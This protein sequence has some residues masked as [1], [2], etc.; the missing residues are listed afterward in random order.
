MPTAARGPLVRGFVMQPH[1]LPGLERDHG[2]GSAV[3]IAELDFVDP[4]R[5]ALDNGADLAADQ[6]LLGQ[7]LEQRNHGEH[8]NVC[9]AEPFSYG[10]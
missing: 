8:F 5:P 10:T 7:V 1:Q 6:S 3:V 2:V 4:R 9:H